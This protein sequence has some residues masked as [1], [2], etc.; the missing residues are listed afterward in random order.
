VAALAVDVQPALQ[1]EIRAEAPSWLAVDA[2]GARV[3]YR[4][5]QAGEQVVIEAHAS[6][7]LRIGDAGAVTYAINGAR[8]RPLGARGEAVTVRL[9]PD[10]V[11]RFVAEAV[12]VT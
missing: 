8:G 3:I 9:T 4:L 1:V 2:D 11:E 12:T 6:I 10:T 5:L 7:D